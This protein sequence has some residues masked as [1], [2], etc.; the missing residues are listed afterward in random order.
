MKVLLREN[1]SKLGKRGDIVE[2]KPGYARNYLIPRNLAWHASAENQRRLDAEKRQYELKMAKIKEE[3]QEIAEKLSG[4]QLQLGVKATEEGHLYGSIGAR[5]IV[6]AFR[7]QG[8][9]LEEDNILLES[10]IK[11]VGKH[12]YH[13]KV[14][15]EIPVVECHLLVFDP[16]IPNRG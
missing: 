10:P 8:F 14:H 9:L 2:V 16:T 7:R 4:M 1:I 15:P 11:E 13:I 3:R 5:Q 6:E 12:T